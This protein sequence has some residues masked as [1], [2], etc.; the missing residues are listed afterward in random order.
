M[1]QNSATTIILLKSLRFNHL[2]PRWIQS[3]E[4]TPKSYQILLFQ[5]TK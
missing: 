3:P 1:P 4:N 5:K 2:Q